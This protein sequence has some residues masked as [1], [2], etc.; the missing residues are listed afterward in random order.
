[1]RQT[2]GD[3]FTPR[4]EAAQRRQ[5]GFGAYA[6][7]AGLLGLISTL[8][9]IAVAQK[10]PAT[11]DAGADGADELRL[12]NGWNDAAEQYMN[13]G[14]YE[15]ARKLYVR[16]LP[17]LEKTIGLEQPVTAAT[18]GNLCIA[19]SHNAHLDAKPVCTRALSVREK[20]FG[21][22][23]PEVAR[24]LSDLGLLYAKEGDLARAES[25]LRRALRID[26]SLPDSP[27]MPGMFNN[28][29]FLYFKERKY[30]PAENAF[31]RAITS[32]ERNRGPDDPDLITILDNLATV[33][34]AHHQPRAAEEHFQRALALAERSFGRDQITS[35]RALIGLARA[36]TVLG[37]SS[38]AETFRQR[39]RGVVARDRQA[40][41]EWGA[42]ADSPDLSLRH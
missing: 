12:A 17:V 21:P 25:L 23:H 2:A 16:S 15:E 32:T 14:A 27:D 18:L 34:L 31:E 1:M 3:R 11:A 40:Y 8:C 28:L 19:S 13:Q 29:G 33:N 5:P 41:L 37:R 24:S 35:V 42:A 7:V 4:P 20:V 6:P 30:T 39:A 9:P 38:E 10:A 22:N 26:G 36:E